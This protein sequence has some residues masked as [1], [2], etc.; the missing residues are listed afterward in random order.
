VHCDLFAEW[1]VQVATPSSGL[2]KWLPLQVVVECPITREALSLVDREDLQRRLP[3]VTLPLDVE[4][5][6]VAVA[7]GIAYPIVEGIACFLRS[8]ALTMRGTDFALSTADEAERIKRS[9][10]QWYDD[11]GWHKTADG[12]YHDTELYSQLAPTG[13]GFYEMDSHLGVLDRL[14]GGTFL[15]DAASGAM[16]HPEVQAYSWAY[17]YRICVDMS[18]TAL[19]EARQKVGDRGFCCLADLTEL[20][21]KRDTI[22][23]IVSNYTIQHIPESQQSTALSELYRILEPA[24]SLCIQTDIQ[25]SSGHRRLVLTYRLARKLGKMLGL[26]HAYRPVPLT[27]RSAPPHQLYFVSHDVAWWR[28]FVSGVCGSCTIECL[29]SLNKTEFDIV[30]GQSSRAAKLV[31][32][33]ESC[34]PQW[35]AHV[36]AYCLIGVRKPGQVA[37]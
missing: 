2:A 6:F 28:A 26:A 23:G 1:R 5:A 31:R 30:F 24:G 21:F 22:A 7:A 16:A 20:P 37:R 29:R 9:V 34:F 18:I 4:G 25:L 8:S 12:V 36:S 27:T 32:A 14:P 35:L 33:F 17:R 15:L 19:R 10:K 11:F 13:H 3:A